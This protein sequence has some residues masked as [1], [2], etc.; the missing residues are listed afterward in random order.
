MAAMYVAWLWK[1]GSH[2]NFFTAAVFGAAGT[3]YFAVFGCD[4][5]SAA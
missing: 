5:E 2:V 4:L 1:K 3:I